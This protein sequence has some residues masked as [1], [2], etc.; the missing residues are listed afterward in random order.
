M[1]AITL[2]LCLVTAISMAQ[3]K[4]NKTI[5]TRTFNIENVNNIKINFYADVTIDVSLEEG[6]TITTDENLFDY[7][8]RNVV[9]NTLYLD[10]KEWISSSKK[11]KIIIG[12]PNLKR[13]ET[14]THDIT[15]IIN[16]NSETLNIISPIGKVFIEGKTKQLNL[17]VELATVDASM[18]IADN[19]YVNIWGWGT[20][21]LNVLNQVDG[22]VSK[23][24]TLKYASTPTSN[25]VKTQKSKHDLE[26]VTSVNQTNKEVRYINFKIKNNSINRNN[27]YVVGSKPDGSKFSYGFPMMPLSKRQETWTTG[28]KIYKVNHIGLRKLLVTITEDN[29]DQI[30][31]LFQK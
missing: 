25:I 13:V 4:G 31:K 15:K 11:T 23:N 17:G 8:Q 30:V 24:G 16:V 26:E 7:I 20:A 22:T 5:E 1:K 9:D 3:I 14:G 12:A 10:Q 28:T 27:F 6:L 2:L 19:V 29:E 18:L 21:T